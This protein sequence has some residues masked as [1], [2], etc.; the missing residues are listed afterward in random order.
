VT[1]IHGAP[2]S[3]RFGNGFPVRSIFSHGDTDRPLS[4]FLLLDY[5]GPHR[6]EATQARLGVGRHPRRGWTGPRPAWAPWC[7]VSP[8]ADAVV[9]R[10][11][12]TPPSASRSGPAA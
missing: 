5:A 4:P 2:R 1:G 6:F 8:R 7:S 11:H 12:R 9:G 3:H 10:M